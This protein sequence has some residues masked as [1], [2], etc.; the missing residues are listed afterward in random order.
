[1]LT[2]QSMVHGK[3]H[4][5]TGYLLGHVDAGIWEFEGVGYCVNDIQMMWTDESQMMTSRGSRTK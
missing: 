3:Y 2:Q 1:M 5:N 4:G